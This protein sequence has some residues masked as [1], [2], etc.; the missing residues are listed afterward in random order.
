MGRLFVSCSHITKMR[1]H[2]LTL[3]FVAIELLAA[4]ATGDSLQYLTPK[5]TVFL[6]VD[7]MGNKVFVHHLEKGQTLYSMAR[8]YGLKM[9]AIR[10]FNPGIDPDG[11]IPPGLAV[12]VP[13]P[14]PAVV[15]FQ[16]SLQAYENYAPVMY[17]VK[18]GDTFYHIAKACFGMS[19]D[20]L[21]QRNQMSSFILHEGQSLLIGWLST[22]G[23][24]DSL[25]M[26]NSSPLGARMRQLYF[27]F[28]AAKSTRKVYTHSGA[29]YWQREK[30]GATDFYALHR[31]ATIGSVIQIT[32]PM[33][34]KVAYA[35]V[36]GKIP[37]RAYGDDTIVVLSPSIAKLLGAKDPRFFVEVQFFK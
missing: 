22:A 27:V 6:R 28:E 4:F 34:K 24:P 29:A 18:Q 1:K 37:D 20:T 9:D 10:A 11:P 33:K 15:K 25:Q 23:I 30:K 26:G 8:F 7:E 17:S 21:Y 16:D 12:K 36:I 32:N 3:I 2:F 14:D 31:T 19:L 13:I 5:D 35:K